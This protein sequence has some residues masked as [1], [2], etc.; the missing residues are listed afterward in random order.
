VTEAV[1]AV[2]LPLTA[3]DGWWIGGGKRPRAGGGNWFFGAV[4]PL[5]F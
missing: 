1:P 4:V 5:D 2:R 3:I